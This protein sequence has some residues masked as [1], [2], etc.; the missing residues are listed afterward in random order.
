MVEER[1]ASIRINNARLTTDL[2]R[3]LGY[4]LGSCVRPQSRA[5]AGNH[6]T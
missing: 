4:Y 3:S 5:S 2:R 1:V 6:R